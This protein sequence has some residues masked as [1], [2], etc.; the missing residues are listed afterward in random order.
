M[1]DHRETHESNVEEN[2][3]LQIDRLVLAACKMI[4][5]TR[6]VGMGDLELISLEAQVWPDSSLGLPQPAVLYSPAI[7]AGYVLSIGLG[8]DTYVFH[9]SM[10]GPPICPDL[11]L[12]QPL[13]ENH[14]LVANA[15]LDLAEK[16]KV[17]YSEI[18]FEG[19]EIQASHG[20]EDSEPGSSMSDSGKEVQMVVVLSCTGHSYQFKGP[21]NGPLQLK[22]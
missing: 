9:T 17:N 8:P 12:P 6:N 3:H 18:A 22:P 20:I 13:D 4:C 2:Q 11:L 16:L 19:S 7:T 15:M 10:Q 5:E 1:P 14:P 21:P